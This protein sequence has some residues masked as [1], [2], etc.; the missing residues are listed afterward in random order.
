MCVY[1][2]CII[3]FIAEA[4]AHFVLSRSLQPTPWS[5]NEMT[6]VRK[7]LEAQHVEVDADFVSTSMQILECCIADKLS[8]LVHLPR[9]GSCHVVDFGVKV[10]A[11]GTY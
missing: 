1:V 5:H 8:L 2:V 7:N 4:Q 3:Y 11:K 6:T 9:Q 10:T